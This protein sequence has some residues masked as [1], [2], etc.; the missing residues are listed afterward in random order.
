MFTIF[1][2]QYSCRQYL[3]DH[4]EKE[5]KERGVQHKF[6]DD[7]FKATNYLTPIVWESIND[8]IVGAKE[9]MK[10]LKDVS[11]LVAKENLPVT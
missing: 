6:G 3:Q 7:L 1:F 8:V 4:V 11:R 10:F 9:I 2:N 5:Y